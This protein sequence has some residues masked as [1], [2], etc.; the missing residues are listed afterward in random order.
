MSRPQAAR[1]PVQLSTAAQFTFQSATPVCLEPAGCRRLA[2][3]VQRIRTW[4]PPPANL[5]F[6]RA[7]GL[8]TPD[9]ARFLDFL[10]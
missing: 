4:L 10:D 5:T 6:G 7:R 9:M 8:H 1:I 2:L 3:A